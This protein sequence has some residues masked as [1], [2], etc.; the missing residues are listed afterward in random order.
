[1]EADTQSGMMGILEEV[2]HAILIHL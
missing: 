2:R 1:V